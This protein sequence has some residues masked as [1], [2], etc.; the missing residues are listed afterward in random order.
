MAAPGLI[1]TPEMYDLAMSAKVRP[2]YDAVTAF[3]KTEIDPITAEFHRLGENRA[4]H[5]GYGEGQL[6][7]LDTVK[8][9][10]KAAGLWN[11]FL[12]DAETGE[13]LSNL[14]YAY[15]AVELG[16]NSIASECFNCSA[17]DTGNMEVLERVG[18]AEQKKQWL[19][20]LLAGEIRSCYGMTEP[21]V[22]SSDAKN[23]ST[24]AVLDGDE[25]VINGEKYW[26]SGAGDPRCKIMICM[27]VTNP[28]GPP[29][30]RQSQIL[31]PMDNPGVIKLGPMT[32]FGDDDAPHGHLHLKLQDVRVPRANIL[33]GEGRGFE[34]SQVRLGPGRIHHCMRA[35]GA[36]DKALEL[37][38]QRGLSR[39]AFGR[40]LAKLG[41]N[42]EVISRARIDIEAMRLMVLQAAKAMDALG[43]AEARVWVSAVKA[44]VPE[45]V[46]QIIDEAMQMHGGIGVSHWTPL[47]K[48]Y[49]SM[50][51]LRF[52]DGPD[53]VHHMVVGRAELSRY[54]TSKQPA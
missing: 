27:V 25:W 20:P 24:R 37:M 39:E 34:I 40:P 46:C 15:I 51:T 49:A 31:V 35:I 29:H 32:V 7:L 16:K 54:E 45:R 41:K 1:R 28:D 48:M 30:M 5:W 52:A 12:P 26:I 53:E 47:A 11:F 19:E 42:A 23:I 43:N 22:A 3:I 36:A 4:E 44:M 6:E 38:C 8:A 2:L 21:N 13:G 17:P 9:K 50:R 10:A 18:T 14:D 33:L